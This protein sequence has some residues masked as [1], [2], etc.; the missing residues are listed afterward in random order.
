MPAHWVGYTRHEVKGLDGGEI[1]LGIETSCDETSAAVVQG[2]RRLLANVISSQVN[3]H[4]LYGGV[5]PEL[6]SRRHVELI[7]PAVAEAL[8]EAGLSFAD[9]DAV[10]VTCGPGLVGALLVGLSYAKAVAL[11][12][13]VPLVGV[14]HTAAHIYANLLVHPELEPPFLSLVVSGGHTSLVYVRAPGAYDLLGQTVDDAA[15]E[16]LDKIARALGLGYPGGPAIER[17]AREGDPEALPLP[18][19]VVREHPLDFSFSGLKTAV[20][21]YLNHLKQ[22]GEEPNKADVAASLQRA[23]VEVLVERALTA[24]ELTGA[25]RLVLAGG[26]AANGELRTRLAEQAAR[27]NLQVL[28]PPPALCTDN[29]AMVACAGYFYLQHGLTAPLSLNAFANLPLGA[30]RG[31]G[32]RGEKESARGKK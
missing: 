23:V 17:L 22:R 29:A 30:E 3:L 15:G 25:R 27:A 10:A 18:R 6:A 11:A 12:R 20:L 26:V 8:K 1:I 9:L 24:A 13:G 4:A 31:W 5:V 19:A 21:N 16:A 7:V 14:H 2:G 28:A 32:K